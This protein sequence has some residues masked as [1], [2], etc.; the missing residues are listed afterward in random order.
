MAQEIQKKTD[1]KFFPF[2]HQHDSMQCGIA[3][4]TTESFILLSQ[5]VFSPFNQRYG[6]MNV[7]VLPSPSALFIIISPPCSFIIY[8]DCAKPMP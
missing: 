8:L 6:I 5:S 4:K 2:Y 7:K 3:C 1:S